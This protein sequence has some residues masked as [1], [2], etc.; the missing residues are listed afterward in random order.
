MWIEALKSDGIHRIDGRIIGVD[1]SYEEPR[2][3]F[4][5]SWD[6][7]GYSTG[8]IFGALNLAENRL[9]VTV[10]PGAVAGAPTSVAFNVDAQDLPI[11]NRSLTG[12]PGSA[13]LRMAGNASRRNGADHRR[14]G[15]GWRHAC[16]NPRI[17]RQSNGVVCPRA[18]PPPD[19]VG[20][21]GQRRGC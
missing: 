9:T 18:A 12:A 5:W 14:F 3:G 11:S 8:S 20:H 19:R 13:A 6:D 16:D 7:L 1:D 21:R 2:P 10:T 4:A 17:R 15:S